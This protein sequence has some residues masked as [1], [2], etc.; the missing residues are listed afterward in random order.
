MLR[1]RNNQLAAPKTGFFAG[2]GTDLVR[3]RS[4]YL[5]AILPIAF[6]V[7]FSYIPMYGVVIAFKDY[8]P[9]I[10]ILGSEW[11]GFKHFLRFFRDP[12]FLRD[13]WNTIWISLCN[14][15]FSFPL[16]IIFALLLNEIRQ[17][18]FLKTVQ[19]IT[20]IP[21]F[22]SLVVLC[23]MVRTFVASD[24]I[25]TNIVSF[26]TGKE[27]TESLL[28]NASNYVTIHVASDIW[29]G[30]G[31]GSIIYVAAITGIDDSLYEAATID[32][33]GRLRQ[34]LNITIPSIMPT[35]I[36]MF[37][38][39]MGNV[40]NVGYEKIML[41]YNELNAESS[42]VLSYYVFKKGIQNS[43]FEL[44]TAAGLFN[45]LV[46]ILFVVGTNK[47]SKHFSE[48]SLW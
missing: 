40:L 42:E 39:R 46:N 17:K 23:G 15:A 9:R 44:S 31:W 5:L 41:L 8:S 25:I 24:G 21:H 20:Y 2:L 37:I 19:T 29:Q 16:P 38:L 10:G 12:Y 33:A 32:G 34:V 13:L 26:F 3:N 48:T 47:I 27:A 30:L 7:I 14:I 1:K 11:I 36:I 45:S 43:E 4:I 18:Y 28:M 6:F 22:I 35:I